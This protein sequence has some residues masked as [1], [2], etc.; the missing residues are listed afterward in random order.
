[1]TLAWQIVQN[2]SNKIRSHVFQVIF[3]VTLFQQIRWWCRWIF[4]FWICKEEYDDEA[5]SYLIRRNLKLSEEQFNATEPKLMDEYLS[6]E[7]WK[8]SEFDKWK[9]QKDREE[10]EKLAKS[11]RY[12]QYQRF[13]RKNAGFPIHFN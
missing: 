3:P 4:K 1:M 8:R 6:K 12:R 2:Y 11:G 9:E 13:M 7:L 10:K 5:K